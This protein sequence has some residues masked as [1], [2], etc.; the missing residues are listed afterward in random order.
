MDNPISSRKKIT[1]EK[2]SFPGPYDIDSYCDWAN[3]FRGRMAY[4]VSAR[5]RT[6]G[7]LVREVVDV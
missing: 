2:S 4:K 5:K 1:E 6:N 7:D 3:R